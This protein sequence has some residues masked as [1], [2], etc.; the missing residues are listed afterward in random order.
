MAKIKELI[1]DL[2]EI[3][4]NDYKDFVDIEFE[5]VNWIAISKYKYLPEYFIEKYIDELDWYYISGIQKMSDN[6]IEKYKDKLEWDEFCHNQVLSE[7]FIDKYRDYV[8][9]QEVSIY[10]N[11]SEE[12]ISKYNVQVNW[13]DISKRQKLSE[14]FMHNNISLLYLDN[15]SMYQKLSENF[16]E[17]HWE[18]LNWE[19]I[20]K[21]QKLSPEFIDKWKM[22]FKVKDII[23]YQIVS[24]EYLEYAKKYAPEF[25][26]LKEENFA[27]KTTEDKKKS[28]INTGR[29]ECYDDYFIAYKA[30]RTDRYSLYNFQYKYEKGGVYESW[31]DCSKSEDSFGLNVGSETFVKNFSYQYENS[32]IVRCKV[33]YEDVGRIVHNG[34]KI[35]CF[36][37]EILN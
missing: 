32:I 6:F 21:Y 22:K 26:Y 35:R 29:Y 34:N 36:K 25:L 7:E 28:V 27:Y 31:C 20:S 2:K 4:G 33:R 1:S 15:I 8:D 23:P 18:Y 30:I 11:L 10:Q 13:F 17:N 14:K 16:I 9:W 5:Y 19:F 24:N 3:V 37:I 12:F